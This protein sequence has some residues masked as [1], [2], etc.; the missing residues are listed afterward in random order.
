MKRALQTYFRQISLFSLFLILV[1]FSGVAFAAES[2]GDW[3]GTYD[4]VMRWV[5]FV[6]FAAIIVKFGAKPL[7]SFIGQ[8]R[9]DVSIEIELLQ[10]E[11]NDMQA[12]VDHTVKKG[13]ESQEQLKKLKERI[14]SEGERHKKEIIDGAKSESALMIE[15]AKRKVE[16]RILVAR[17]NFRKDLI[18]S[19]TDIALK[20]LP[21]LVT[22]DDQEKRLK[23]FVGAIA[24]N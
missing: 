16:Y 5:N 23:L 18:D 2:T 8:Q 14:L 4:L 22:K 9:E 17:K 11:K 21:L 10:K 3:R 6:I 24:N 20:N 13:E 19:A 12:K 7:K 1:A 15:D